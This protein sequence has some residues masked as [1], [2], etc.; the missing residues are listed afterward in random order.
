MDEFF[1]FLDRRHP[2]LGPG[3]YRVKR[4]GFYPF[5]FLFNIVLFSLLENDTVF[6]RI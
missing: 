1:N 4:E 3:R 5:S 2:M 6:H